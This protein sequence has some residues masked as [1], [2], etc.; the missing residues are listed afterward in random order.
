ML[1]STK[2]ELLIVLLS[3][4]DDEAVGCTGTNEDVD[5]LVVTGSFT[6]SKPSPL[7]EGSMSSSVDDGGM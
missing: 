3:V 4:A 5:V 1:V 2:S 7:F 6:L